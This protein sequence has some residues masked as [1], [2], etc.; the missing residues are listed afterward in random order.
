MIISDKYQYLFVELPRTGTTA[1]SNELI[2]NYSGRPI[3]SKHTR[4]R[5][6]YRNASERERSYFVFSCIR[7][8]ID[9]TYS[10]FHK[11]KNDHARQFSRFKKRRFKSL[12]AFYFYRQYDFVKRT[13]ASFLGYL[14][15]FYSIIPYD[16]W[17]TL[18]HDRFDAVIRFENLN[19]D[20]HA[21]LRKLGIPRV[22]ALPVINKTAKDASLPNLLSKG[23]IESTLNKIFGVY[24]DKMNYT[25]PHSEQPPQVSRR[26]KIN[27]DIAHIARSFYWNYIKRK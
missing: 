7:N 3:Y 24:L 19:E 22:R 9:R 13:N 18:E 14:Q 16:D 26:M 1:I 10:L 6:F 8:P 23:D 11:I 17:A 15:K 27:Y 5:T 12:Q 20:F 21:V 25:F 4:Y 2:E